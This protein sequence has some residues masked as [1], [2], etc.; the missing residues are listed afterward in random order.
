[1]AKL[2]T[3][4]L[5]EDV[6]LKN[7]PGLRQT[8]VVG[9][10]VIILGYVLGTVSPWFMILPLFPAAGLMISGVAGFCPMEWFLQRMPWNKEKVAEPVA[11]A[12]AT[13]TP[14]NATSTEV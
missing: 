14:E 4:G 6:T 2:K 13:A 7:L 5:T 10:S 8:F 1:M 11:E 12:V 9:S 3:K